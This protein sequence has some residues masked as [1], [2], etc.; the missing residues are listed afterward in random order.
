MARTRVGRHDRE[1]A[2]LRLDVAGIAAEVELVRIERALARKHR[3]DQP[4][5]PAGGPDGGRWVPEGSDPAVTGSIGRDGSADTR[6]DEVVT[7]DGS[8][9][10]SIRIRANPRADWDE[11]H[12]VTAPDGA[13]T[14]FET[15]GL[16]QTVR[17]GETGEIL[18]RSTLTAD[19][20]VPDAFVQPARSGMPGGLSRILRS[21][22]AAGT[23]LFGVLSG[24]GDGR[25]A[26]FAAPAS[27]YVPGDAYDGRAMWVGAVDQSELDRLCPRNRE[28]QALADTVAADVRASGTYTTPQDFGNKVHSIIASRINKQQDPGF[29]A[30]TS[31]HPIVDDKNRYGTKGVIRLDVLEESN[32]STV[33]VYDHKTGESGLRAPRAVDIM[34]IV[35]KHF[36]GTARF[37]MVEI[38]PRP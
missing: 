9:V 31:Y 22:E 16:T 34:T 19:G 32:K 12:T 8:R 29:A 21:L 18:G 38:R 3:S 13:R 6:T 27:E 26:V 4:R 20:A 14:V 10:L 35:Q 28:V 5:A 36:P 23:T 11:R 25:K 17:D 33:C 37:I 30:E 7:E 24:R 15:S 2:A 1:I